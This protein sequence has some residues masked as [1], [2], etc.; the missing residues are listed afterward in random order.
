MFW[1]KSKFI[2]SFPMRLAGTGARSLLAAFK[3]LSGQYYRSVQIGIPHIAAFDTPGG[4]ERCLKVARRFPRINS[5]SE[6][7]LLGYPIPDSFMPRPHGQRRHNVVAIGRWDALRHKLPHMLMHV[8]DKV[9][10]Q[11]P[12]ATFEIFGRLTPALE[13]WHAG[14]PNDLQNRV[15]LR[16]IQPSTVIAEAIGSSQ[17]LYCPSAMDGIPLAVVEGL[18]GGCSV[19]GLDT[20]DVAGLHWAVSEGD[21]SFACQDSVKAHASAILN[22]LAAWQQGRRDPMKISNKWKAW[23]SAHEVARKTIQLLSPPQ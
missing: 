1:R 17:I 10:P 18:C 6:A 9:L 15:L 16:G 13:Q 5:Q 20:L 14:M 12:T 2:E 23:F 19:A 22:E 8:I 11:H 7:V 21:G 4:M 3:G